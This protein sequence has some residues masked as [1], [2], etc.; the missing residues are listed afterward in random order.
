[1]KLKGVPLKDKLACEMLSLRYPL[2][3][4]QEASENTWLKAKY[5]L[6]LTCFEM[7]CFTTP[8]NA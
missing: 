6:F 8:E 5:V 2:A 7:Q 1:M 3:S 4:S